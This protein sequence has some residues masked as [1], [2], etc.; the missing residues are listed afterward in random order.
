MKMS[1]LK[2][3]LAVALFAPISI[4]AQTNGGVLAD[5]KIGEILV[6][7]KAVATEGS[8]LY[9]TIIPDA[10]SYIRQTATEVLA[11]LYDVSSD[12]I[13][14]VDRLHYTLEDVDGISA[15]GGGN[16]NIS[17]F[18]STRHIERSFELNDT[19]R[20][21][22][23]TRGVLLH[24]LT[25]AFQLEP[26]GVGNYGNSRVFRAFIEGM[27]DA[28]RLANGGFEHPEH[29]AGGGH[30]LVGYQSAGYFFVWIRDNKNADFLRKFNRSALEVV[31]WSFD[32]AIKYALGK[33][34]SIDVLWKEYLNA[35]FEK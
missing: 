15:K 18:Y 1:V 25:H 26:H 31:P 34:Y 21:L 33:D 6:E 32:G 4:M 11:T 20:L 8:R 30:Y 23:E 13:P 19:S 2:L 22:F 35:Q 29:F 10:E 14:T 24:E 16:G 27:A 28:V 9:H 7:D 5:Y 3:M 17:I 12:T